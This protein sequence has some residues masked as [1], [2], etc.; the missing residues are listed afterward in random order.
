M[1]LAFIFLS[2][3]IINIVVI[4]LFIIRFGLGDVNPKINLYSILVGKI[5]VS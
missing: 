3:M 1:V 5:L 4:E 2:L